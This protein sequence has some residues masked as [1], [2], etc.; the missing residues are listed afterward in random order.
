MRLIFIRHAEPDYSIDSLTEKGWREAKLLAERVSRW[1][2]KQFYVSP[3]GRAR[4]T[5]SCT[6]KLMDREA[7]MYP[8]LRE[9]EGH[10]TNTVT[11]YDHICWDLMPDHWTADEGMYDR[12]N[13]ARSD[14]MRTST[15]DVSEECRKVYDGID[16]IMAEHG[17]ER[18]GA[19]YKVKEH[20]D[21]TI[22]IFCHFGVSM[23]MLSRILGVSAPVLLQGC[24]MA[25]SSITVLNSEERV[26][27]LAY[28]RCQVIGDTS[29]LYMAGEPVSSSGYFAE[30]FSL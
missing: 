23:V 25:P 15:N 29:H 19:Y 22:V 1:D 26:D 11:G 12:N 5:A 28:F 8:W 13:W 2:V 20:N 21:Y 9:F 3:L 24:F 16:N 27:D 14:I 7:V 10:V 17:Y 6:L 30:A 4:D 18:Y